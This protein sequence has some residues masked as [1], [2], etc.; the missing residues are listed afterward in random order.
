MKYQTNKNNL[1][2]RLP[3]SMGSI[4]LAA[5]VAAALTIS[6]PAEAKPLDYLV[7]LA[8]KV[9]ANPDFKT[10]DT[11]TREF[12]IGSRERMFVTYRDNGDK[13]IGEGD[14]LSI[15]QIKRKDRKNQSTMVLDDLHLDGFSSGTGGDYGNGLPHELV[16][17][18]QSKV[19]NEGVLYDMHQ[20]EVVKTLI[21]QCNYQDKRR[22][23]RQREKN[24]KP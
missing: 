19:K 23:K 17:Q 11:Y 3:K 16:T 9:K 4:R 7:D 20:K 13:N 6:S 1:N 15:V 8:Q 24:P 10:I 21:R 5:T 14:R 18:F 12:W 2:D 22:Q